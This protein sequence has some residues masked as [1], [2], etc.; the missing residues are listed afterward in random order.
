MVFPNGVFY[1]AERSEKRKWRYKMGLL[2]SVPSPYFFTVRYDFLWLKVD[3]FPSRPVSTPSSLPK[4]PLNC[5]PEDEIGFEGNYFP[6]SLLR[7][8]NIK[9]K[10]LKIPKAISITFWFRI[11][12]YNP[13]P[14]YDYIPWTLERAENI[15]KYYIIIFLKFDFSPALAPWGS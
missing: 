9:K 3:L 10:I 5:T 11:N 8:V 7:E 13:V 12:L 1:V 6:Q 14:T 2:F 4:D 15:L